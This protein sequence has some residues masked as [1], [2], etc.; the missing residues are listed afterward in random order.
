MAT[1][2][3]DTRAVV[4]IKVFDGKD[5]GWSEWCVK[6]EGYT[7][8]LD[9]DQAMEQAAAFPNEVE[10]SALGAGA[11]QVSRQLYALL[12]NKCEGKALGIIRLCPK[13]ARFEAWRRLKR[14]YEAPIGGR[15][16]AMLRGI[17]HPGKEWQNAHVQ[18]KDCRA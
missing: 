11:H 5:E 13:H 8:L 4:H 16:A 3:L 15:F 14:E 18:G 6:F 10:N 12:I 2:L 9:W 17:L 7:A 1:A